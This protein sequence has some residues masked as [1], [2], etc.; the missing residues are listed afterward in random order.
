MNN[1]FV[2]LFFFLVAILTII[3]IVFVY[4]YGN[5]IEWIATGRTERMD[6]LRDKIQKFIEALS[7][8]KTER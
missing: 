3:P 1:I 5:A 2:R 4:S 8:N 7:Y 6:T